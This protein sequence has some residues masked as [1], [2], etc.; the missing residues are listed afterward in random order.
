[1]NLPW[2][3][4]KTINRA[5]KRSSRSPQLGVVG[6]I[7]ESPLPGDTGNLEID[8]FLSFFDKVQFRILGLC[9]IK[10]EGINRSEHSASTI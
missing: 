5:A 6:E 9:K 3:H 2:Q 10:T 7:H 8:G 4:C 1:M